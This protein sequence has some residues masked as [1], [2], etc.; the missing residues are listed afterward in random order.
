MSYAAKKWHLQVVA[1]SRV[2]VA[3][4]PAP[5]Q[6]AVQIDELPGGLCRMYS[7][8]EEKRVIDFGHAVRAPIEFH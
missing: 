5:L 1:V 6:V 3:D 4:L 8:V 2:V 7:H